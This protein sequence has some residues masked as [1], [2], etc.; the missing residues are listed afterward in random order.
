MDRRGTHSNPP[1]RPAWLAV[2]GQQNFILFRCPA[3]R[4]P[5]GLLDLLDFATLRLL[6]SLGFHLGLQNGEVLV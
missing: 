5:G 6:G 4:G 2:V 1:V 3:G